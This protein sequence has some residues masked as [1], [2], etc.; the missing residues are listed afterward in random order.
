MHISQ[1]GLRFGQLIFAKSQINSQGP[2][3]NHGD[4]AITTTIKALKTYDYL[5]QGLEKKHNMDVL[6]TGEDNFVS[7][8]F[9]DRQAN[10]IQWGH[11][12]GIYGAQHYGEHGIF[13]A[14][15]KGFKQAVTEKAQGESNPFRVNLQPH[16]ILG[17]DWVVP[18]A[19][20]DGFESYKPPKTYLGT[21][22]KQKLGAE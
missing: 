11:A 17:Q 14:F 6:V 5:V 7:F 4:S 15:L 2:G 3:R 20:W 19:K 13:G 22:L 18:N 1:S 21:L 9:V 8:T 12:S 10:N 16:T